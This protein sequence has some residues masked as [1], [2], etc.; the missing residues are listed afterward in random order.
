MVVL[1]H[2]PQTLSPRGIFR[3]GISPRVRLFPYDQLSGRG[4]RITDIGWQSRFEGVIHFF[5]GKTHMCPLQEKE[6]IKLFYICFLYRKIVNKKFMSYIWYVQ[7]VK[8]TAGL[9]S[10]FL[11]IIINLLQHFF[12]RYSNL[13]K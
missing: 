9:T 1:S 12:F 7:F 3:T 2:E 11:K 6:E 10:L 13:D 8:K 5:C 4:W